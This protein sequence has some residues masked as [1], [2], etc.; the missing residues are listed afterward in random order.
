MF[1]GSSPTLQALG[2]LHP[3]PS[4]GD[5]A[6]V[7]LVLMKF[8]TEWKPQTGSVSQHD[9]SENVFGLDGGMFGGRIGPPGLGNSTHSTELDRGTYQ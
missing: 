1:L 3:N 7:G 8:S 5:L 6:V 2:F 9:A 4:A